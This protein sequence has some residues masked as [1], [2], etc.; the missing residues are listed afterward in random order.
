MKVDINKDFKSE[1][2]KKKI[3]KVKDE[4]VFEAYKETTEG[5]KPIF[6]TREIQVRHS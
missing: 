4:F 5:S 1:K 6:A 3:C 2:K